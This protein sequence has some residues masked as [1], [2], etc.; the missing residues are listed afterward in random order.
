M[1]TSATAAMM[2]IVASRMVEPMTTA[3]WLYCGS[4]VDATVDHPSGSLLLPGSSLIRRMSS[5]AELDGF[6]DEQDRADDQV[7]A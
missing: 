6:D 4:G 5:A 1:I 3:W 7:A 2:A